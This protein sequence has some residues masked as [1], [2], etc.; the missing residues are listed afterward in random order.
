MTQKKVK[1]INL[2]IGQRLR[3]LRHRHRLNQ[4]DM[5]GILDITSAGY[6]K[7]ETGI[8]EIGCKHILTIKDHFNISTDWLLSGK[9]STDSQDFE[10]NREDVKKMLADMKA[11]KQVLFS[12]LSQY[13]EI[14]DDQVRINEKKNRRLKIDEGE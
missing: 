2:E 5:A 12:I 6:Q 10:E 11:S 8:N 13:Y 4:V 14:I 9:N 1:S 3:E 7:I